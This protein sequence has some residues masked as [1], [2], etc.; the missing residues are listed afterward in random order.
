MMLVG[1]NFSVTCTSNM[2]K[3][4]N[5]YREEAQPHEVS[6]F[7]GVDLVKVC[8]SEDEPREDTKTCTLVISNATLESSGS[9][10]CMAMNEMRC[11]IIT[12]FVNVEGNSFSYC[13]PKQT[14]IEDMVDGQFH[15]S[16][17]YEQRPIRAQL[18]IDKKKK[19]R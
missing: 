14:A 2:S 8:G 19:C 10:S 4:Y 6:M 7:Y 18:Y 3:E 15:N 5:N 17:A 1:H 11:T 9:Y 13:M 16:V 12:I